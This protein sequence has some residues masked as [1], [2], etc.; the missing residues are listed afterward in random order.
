MNKVM[1]IAFP[2]YDNLLASV[3]PASAPD[4]KNLSVIINNLSPE[5]CEIIYALILHH[6]I[7][8]QAAKSGIFRTKKDI[9]NPYSG[10]TFEGGKGLLYIANNLPPQLQH[11]IYEYTKQL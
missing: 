3:T 1:A 9:P 5:H 11:I 2:L 7:L 10:K 4:W 6:Y 8:E